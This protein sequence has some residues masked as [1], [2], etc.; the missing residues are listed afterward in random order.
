MRKGCP[1]VGTSFCSALCI[2][3][4]LCSFQEAGQGNVQGGIGISQ[5]G[6]LHKS[7]EVS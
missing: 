5:F 6:G 2:F 4:D 1:E 7:T 3:Y